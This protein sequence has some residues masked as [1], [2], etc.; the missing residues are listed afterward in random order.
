MAG[1]VER[2]AVREMRPHVLHA[3]PIDQ[4]LGQLE[5]RW[6]LAGSELL[7]QHAGA[8]CRRRHNDL[9]AVEDAGEAPRQRHALAR[10]AGV[11]VHLPA[12][13]L[14]EREVH[15]AAQPLEQAHRRAARLR[16]ERV[17]EAGDEE[18]DAHV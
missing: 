2:H 16:E 17:V 8:G 7:T 4:K 10:I 13:G 6:A 12:A 1:W 5:H 3:E 9:G 15:L 14:L 18:A 11:H